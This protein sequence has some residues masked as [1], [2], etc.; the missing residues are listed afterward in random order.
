[1]P[2]LN[3]LDRENDIKAAENVPY[4]LLKVD[5]KLSYGDP[6]SENML[7]KGDNL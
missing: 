3:W 6:E 1:M 7:I 4:R 2:I 5:T